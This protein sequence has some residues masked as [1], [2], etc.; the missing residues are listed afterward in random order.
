MDPG[1]GRGRRRQPALLEP[2]SP[3]AIGQITI[4]GVPNIS[5]LTAGLPTGAIQGDYGVGVPTLDQLRHSSTV[6]VYLG[7]GWSSDIF[8][9]TSL[10]GVLGDVRVR[11]ALSL[12][13]N[14]ESII[15]SVYQGTALLP[16][17]LSNPGTFGYGKSVFAKAYDS[18][19]ALT[20]NIAKA[21]KLVKEAGATG[22]TITI[23]TTSQLAVYAGD[24]GAYEAAAQAIGLRVVLK[25]VPAQDYINFL[26]DPKLRASI[27][28]LPAVDYAD[29]ADPAAL[30]AEVVVPGGLQNY[31]GFNDPQITAVLDRARGTAGPDERAALVAEAEKLAAQQLPSIPDVQPDTVLLLGNGLTGAVSSSAYLFAP[32]ADQSGRPRLRDELAALRAHAADIAGQPTRPADPEPGG[33]CVRVSRAIRQ[34]AS[35][36]R[37]RPGRAARAEPLT[38]HRAR[39]G[40]GVP[41]ARRA[42]RA[43]R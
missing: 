32:W 7:P 8:I 35:R 18:S 2:S 1:R 17:W 15:N 29:Y 20:Q 26:I 10:K 24:T 39:P 28:G 40:Q 9:V 23:G 4:K 22:K 21:Q 12:A 5:T 30:L 41:G 33:A 25:S 3:P 36:P 6:R 27:D 43:S 14:R 11:Q 38:T 19:P 31:D 16:R 37:Q 34:A 42:R 13:L